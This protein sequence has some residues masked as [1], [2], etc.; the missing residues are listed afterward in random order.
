MGW[1]KRNL[2]TCLRTFVNPG[3]LEDDAK[4]SESGI[5]RSIP[6]GT[7]DDYWAYIDTLPLITKPEA[8]GMDDNADMTCQQAEATI[9]FDLLLSMQP[10]SGGGAGKSWDEIVTEAAVS[11]AESIP[12]P[13]LLY[14]IQAKYPVQYEESMNTVLQQEIIRFNRLLSVIKKTLAD[15]QKA[16]KGLVVMSGDLEAMGQSIFNNQVPSV[17]EA[18]AY[19][20]LKPLSLWVVDLQKRLDFINSWIAGG[21]PSAFWF[22]GFFFPQAFLT[23]TLQNYARKY[24]VSIDTVSFQ[25]DVQTKTSEEL[26][27]GE[28]PEN[29]VYIFGMFLE[30]CRWDPNAWSLVD[31]RPKELFTSFPAIWLNPIP[32]RT[33]P[34]N[35]F[36]CPVYKI[37]TRKGTLSTT[38]HSTNFVVPSEL[39][40]NKPEAYWVK[41]GVALFLSLAY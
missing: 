30:G 29:G 35:F 24:Q 12:G 4:F 19:P 17:W 23:G 37:L 2:Y 11:M 8:F 39:P 7:Y 5:Y 38:G 32:N 27:A 31:S 40:S 34:E 20:S 10:K 26:V 21:I 1:D 22:S 3:I 15:I 33:K 28:K 9:L 14:E 16:I 41:R 13:W 25:F 6:A 18:K 36:L